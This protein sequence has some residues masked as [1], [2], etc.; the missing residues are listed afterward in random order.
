[1]KKRLEGNLYCPLKEVVFRDQQNASAIRRCPSKDVLCES[2]PE[3]LSVIWRCPILDNVTCMRFQ[4]IKHI[5][6]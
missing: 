3:Q 4:G 2:V 6:L 1:M 5:T